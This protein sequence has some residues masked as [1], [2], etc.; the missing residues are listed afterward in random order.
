MS[1][2][3]A[4]KALFLLTKIVLIITGSCDM[5]NN[6]NRQFTHKELIVVAYVICIIVSYF[7]GT[8]NLAYFFAQYKGFDIWSRGSHNA[9]AS[10]AVITMGWKIGVIV[11]LADILKAVAAVTLC[12]SVFPGRPLIG[13]IAGVACVIGHIFPFY[14]KFHGGKGFASYLGMILA[15][16]WRVFIVT[17]IGVLLITV[18]TNYI[19]L[20]TFATV[21]S[22]PVYLY[23]SGSGWLLAV[24]AAVA[25]CVI[26]YKHIPNMIRLAKGEEIGLRQV[27]GKN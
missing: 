21:L 27:G 5:V 23:L 12:K 25:S 6:A 18:I 2:P 26:L 14:L 22:F 8:V 3:A 1:R 11:A 24:V 17:A 19:V 13:V 15:I 10:N 4:G 7:I 20:G 9:G 16:D